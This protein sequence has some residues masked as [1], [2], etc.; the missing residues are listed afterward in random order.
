MMLLKTRSRSAF[1]LIELMMAVLISTIITS[2]LFGLFKIQSRQLMHQDQQMAMHQNLR[3]AADILSRSARMA[4]YGTG[5]EVAGPMGYDYTA[6]GTSDDYA[7]PAI[8]AWDGGHPL[9]T[10]SRWC[11]RIL[12]WR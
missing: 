11:M 4:G 5:G 12:L 9:P 1:T 6:D 3:F 8:I 7:L 2:A 10:R